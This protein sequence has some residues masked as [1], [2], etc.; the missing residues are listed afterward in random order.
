MAACDRT[1]R[2]YITE[3]QT[4]LVPYPRIHF[5]LTSASRPVLN[6]R[7]KSLSRMQS[8]QRL[9]T[10]SGEKSPRSAPKDGP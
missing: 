7:K 2:P 9:T 3:F 6:V 5:V 4:N 10:S 8:R 1:R